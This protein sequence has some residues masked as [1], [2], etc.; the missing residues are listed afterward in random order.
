MSADFV[1]LI[2]LLPLLGGLVIGLFGFRLRGHSWRLGVPA[3][4]AAF[5]L[6][7]WTLYTVSVDGPMHVALFQLQSALPGSFGFSLLIDRLSA[8]MMVLITGVSLLV[9]VYS[10][11]YMQGERGYARFYALLGLITA[12]LLGLVCS[13]DLLSLFVFWQLLS[14]LLY[15]LL[16]YDY[17]RTAACDNALKTFLVHRFGDLAFFAGVVLAY[18]VYGTLDFATLFAR[19]SEAAVPLLLWEPSGLAINATTAVTLLIFIGAMA[20]SAQF[21]LH[22]WL[23]DTMDTPT[24]VSALMHAGIVN[25]GGFLLNR[26]APLYGLSSTTLFVVFLIGGLTVMLGA[27][28]M[29]T[30]PDVKKTLGFST[31]GQMG[32]MTLECGL[33]AFGLAVFHLIAHGLFKAT[34]FLASG[35]GIHAARLE[36][37][38]PLGVARAGRPAFSRLTWGTGLVL[39]LVLPLLIVLLA[40]DVVDVPLLE[41]HG[42]VI[43]LFFSWVTASQA[44]FSLYRLHGVDSWKVAASMV[45]VLLI[46]VMTYLWAGEAFS[47]FLYPGPKEV[48]RYLAAAALPGWLFDVLVVTVVLLIVGVW[49]VVYARVHGHEIV[50]PAWLTAVRVRLYVWLTNRLYVDHLYDRIGSS[51]LLLARGMNWGLVGGRRGPRWLMPA[52]V[53]GAG[54]VLLVTW[55]VPGVNLAAV[56]LLACMVL[57]SV[58]PFHAA[59]AET[60]GRLPGAWASLYVVLLPMPGFGGAVFLVERMPEEVRPIVGLLGLLSVGYGSCAALVEL[61]VKRRLALAYTAQLGLAWWWLFLPGVGAEHVLP[62]VGAVTILAAGLFSSWLF[63]EHRFGEPTLDQFGGLARSMPAFAVLFVILLMGAMGLPL[64]PLFSSLAAAMMDSPIGSAGGVAVV[65]VA[66]FLAAWQYGQLLH[67]IWFGRPR[68]PFLAREIRPGEAVVLLLLA[69]A[70]L[71]AAMVPWDPAAVLQAAPDVWREALR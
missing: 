45:G 53:T 58:A 59:L 7:V 48:D 66:W 32:Y 62:Y 26:L 37:R 44:I 36:P 9:H 47:R 17:E 1:V 21:P 46:I 57:L 20:K 16:A 8:V 5:V 15:L 22:V 30:Q 70:S 65:C 14:W 71:A 28:M 25:A 23:P 12:I 2:H 19:A 61:Q 49:V 43:F 60:V 35:S 64:F 3:V 4:A 51:L 56:Q 39:T 6:S 50:E 24:P 29:L 13:A 42:S 69:G 18:R 52:L 55:S 68:V 31:M 40:N 41:A 33:G 10:I 54:A 34:L 27:S 11:R 67:G 38:S 63:L